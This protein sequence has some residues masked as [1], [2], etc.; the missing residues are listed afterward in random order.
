MPLGDRVCVLRGAFL[1][2]VDRPQ[3]LYDRPSNLFVAG[4]IGSPGMNLCEAELAD[5]VVRFGP[6]SL[7]LDEAALAARPPLPAYQ[8]RRLALGIRPHGLTAG[9]PAVGGS[10]AG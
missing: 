9:S 5:G 4:F 2:Q 6:H 7:R 3:V 1:Q 10:E 8:G